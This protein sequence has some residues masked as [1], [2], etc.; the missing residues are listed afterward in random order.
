MNKCLYTLFTLAVSFASAQQA[1]TSATAQYP[2][3]VNFTAQQDHQHMMQQLGIKSLMPGPSG[4]ESAANHAIK[5]KNGKNTV[6]I[7]LNTVKTLS[8]TL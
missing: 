7:N 2:P 6:T 3:V 5:L 1:T 4:D 8:P